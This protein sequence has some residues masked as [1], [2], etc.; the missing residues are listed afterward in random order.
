MVLVDTSV[1][2]DHLRN[3]QDHLQFLLRETEV[4]CHP[5][6]IG[7]LACGNLTNRAE[8]L[9]LLKTLPM[10]PQLNFDEYL[11]F[12]DEHQ[13]QGRGIGFVDVH[14]LASAALGQVKLWTND[15]RLKST[16][17]DLDLDYKRQGTR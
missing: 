2:I 15:K 16:A 6:V 10:A 12:I 13:L 14:L 4:V 5:F 11:F 1:W 9:T 8:I 3:S 17:A 7:E